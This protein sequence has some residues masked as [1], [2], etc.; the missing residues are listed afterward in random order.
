M[1]GSEW[2]EHALELQKKVQ[3]IT[4]E[5]NEHF[6]LD[7]DF[8]EKAM[9]L[10]DAMNVSS[11][12]HKS[13]VENMMP[14]INSQTATA[15][16]SNEGLAGIANLW[17]LGAKG[18]SAGDQPAFNITETKD[19]VTLIAPLPGLKQ[20][21]DIS[22]R[23]QCNTLYISGRLQLGSEISN[24]NRSINLPSDVVANGASASYHNGYLIIKLQKVKSSYS[25]EVQF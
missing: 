20:K 22:L 14:N 13:M 12:W 7:K 11:G 2:L 24:F 25:I 10:V 5:T 3:D 15:R 16:P 8:V 4:K 23:L 18:V 17:S 1:F 19:Y 21:D 6:N 9:K